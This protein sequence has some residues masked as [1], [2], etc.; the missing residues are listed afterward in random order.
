M[1]VTTFCNGSVAIMTLSSLSNPQE[2][3]EDA[4]ASARTSLWRSSQ[5][6]K[7]TSSNTVPMAPMPSIPYISAARSSHSTICTQLRLVE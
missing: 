6:P 1:C 5:S 2:W 4:T 7:N 3:S